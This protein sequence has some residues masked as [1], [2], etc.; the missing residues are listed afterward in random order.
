MAFEL[1]W[2]MKIRLRSMREPKEKLKASESDGA[3]GSES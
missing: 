2:G 1:L 3:L